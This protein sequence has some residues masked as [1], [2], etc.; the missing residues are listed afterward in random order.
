MLNE[1]TPNSHNNTKPT[2][3][4][5]PALRALPNRMPMQRPSTVKMMIGLAAPEFCEDL[6]R[7]AAARFGYSYLRLR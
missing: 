7:S 6:D 5:S 2:P 4:L 1:S 3:T